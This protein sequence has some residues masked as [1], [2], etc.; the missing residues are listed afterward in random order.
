MHVPS[1]RV[2]TEAHACRQADHRTAIVDQVSRV[3]PAL[4]EAVRVTSVLLTFGPHCRKTL[5]SSYTK[6]KIYIFVL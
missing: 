3:Q 2:K 4:L 6:I 5:T 1:S